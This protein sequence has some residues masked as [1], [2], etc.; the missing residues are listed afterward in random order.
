MSI[1]PATAEYKDFA[2]FC[3]G[4]RQMD[5]HHWHQCRPPCSL[6]CIHMLCSTPSPHLRVCYAIFTRSVRGTWPVVSS[7]CTLTS[8]TWL[9]CVQRVTTWRSSSAVV[10]CGCADISGQD[11]LRVQRAV[12]YSDFLLLWR[13]VGAAG[14]GRRGSTRAGRS[15][16]TSSSSCTCSVLASTSL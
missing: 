7:S 2:L 6:N 1:N 12:I 8:R 3:F 9:F 11:S 10:L 14:A 15:S 5:H 16:G 4:C 13:R